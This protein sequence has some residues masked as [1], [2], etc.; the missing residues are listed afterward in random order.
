MNVLYG[1]EHIALCLDSMETAKEE[2]SPLPYMEFPD[3]P[4]DAWFAPY[5]CAAWS[6]G[7]ISGYPDGLF[8][9]EEGVKFVEAAK[10]LS[11][12]FGMTGL[13]LPNFG[14]A[15]VLWYQPYVEFLAAANAIPYS[16]G[17][18]GR[19]IDRGEMAELIYRLKDYPVAITTPPQR[20]KRAEDVIYPVEF[21]TYENQ[22]KIFSFGYPN[23]WPE[24]HHLS[25]GYY[26]GRSPYI[27]S[28]WTIYFGPKSIN[29]VGIGTSD[30]VRRD[31]WIDGYKTE[32]SALILDAVERDVLFITVEEETI[33]NRIPTLVIKEE[34]G[35]CVDKR[36]FLFGKDWI[37]AINIRC[38]GQDE[39]LENM[40][41]Q[42]LQTFTQIQERPP[43]HRK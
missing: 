19:P 1:E 42:V 37:Y 11:L 27:P 15:N 34:I 9:P 35:E 30:C 17:E 31:M 28:E 5:V 21:I 24:P 32:D 38:G 4:Y 20:S 6:S 36:G 43:E 13:E 10:M 18:L 29:C 14:T 16:I 41:N 23:T 2:I 12:G 25:R 33:V 3:V 40:F 22:E 7:I 8:R 39:L 26:D